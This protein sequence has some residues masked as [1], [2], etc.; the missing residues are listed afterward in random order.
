VVSKGGKR[1]ASADLSVQVPRGSSVTVNSISADQRISD[2][3]G[4]QRLQSVS[5][6]IETTVWGEDVQVK[7]ISGD[8]RVQGHHDPARA[9]VNTVSGNIDLADVAG[10]LELQTVS[11][12]MEVRAKTLSRTRIRTT[13]GAVQW[14]AALA[15]DGRIEA[16]SVNGDLKFVL[17][18]KPSARFDIETFN[19]EID[20]CFGP[21]ASRTREHAPGHA[22]RFTQGDGKAQVRVKTLNGGVEIC[23]E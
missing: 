4:S 3:R 13:N 8:V 5:G 22:L 2:V 16:E 10:D 12:D 20:N 15:D 17:A 6:E 7:T 14:R 9:T 21:E 1:Y 11:G 19:G 23:A 18:G